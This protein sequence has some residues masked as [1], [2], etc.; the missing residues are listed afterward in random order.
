MKDRSRTLMILGSIVLVAVLSIGGG[1]LGARLGSAP[2]SE[3]GVPSDLQFGTS[4]VQSDAQP[5][6]EY[7]VTPIVNDPSALATANQAEIA[8]SFQQQFRTVASQTL[9]VVVEVNVVN[10]VTQSVG[11]SPL[12]FFFGNPRDG[13]RER[14]FERPGMGSGV[15][16]ARD[17]SAVYVLTNHHVA[18]EADEI[19]IVLS[20]GRSFDAEIV[21]SD[22]LMTSL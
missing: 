19:E 5:T 17:G 9:P 18:G 2:A 6:E 16:V 7:R 4:P 20:D 13:Q 11:D 8:R 1:I 12:D 21:G 14:E 15:I 10:R 3:A 22:E